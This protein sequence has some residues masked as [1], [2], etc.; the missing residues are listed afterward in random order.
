MPTMTKPRVV[1]TAPAG[2]RAEF[3]RRSRQLVLYRCYFAPTGPTFGDRDAPRAYTVSE[4]VGVVSGPATAMG[5]VRSLSALMEQ[6]ALVQTASQYE[7]TL[8]VAVDVE[9]AHRVGAAVAHIPNQ[10]GQRFPPSGE[11]AVLWIPFQQNKQAW[12]RATRIA[13]PTE[14]KGAFGVLWLQ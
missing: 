14:S 10:S 3:R 9:D 6:A 11:D 2:V 13:V 12:G 5:A 7:A 4:M 8:W 1:Y